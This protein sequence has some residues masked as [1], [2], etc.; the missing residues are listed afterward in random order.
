MVGQRGDRPRALITGASAGIGQAFAERLARDGYDLVLVARRRARLEALAQRLRGEGG[1]AADVVVADL[2]APAGL[3]AVE[4]RA[5]ADEALTLLV[6]NAG[7][8]GY[9]PFIDLPADRAE[10]L[11]RLHVVAVTRLTRAALP[12]LV[13]RG[14]GAVVNVASMLAFSAT[15]PASVPLP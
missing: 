7:F 9:M 5:A 12:G 11:I 10:E 4:A 2:T 13:A 14:R 6:N 15:V 1:G 3:R 8:A